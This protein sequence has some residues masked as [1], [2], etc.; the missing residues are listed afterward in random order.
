MAEFTTSG[1]IFH[2]VTHIAEKVVSAFNFFNCDIIIGTR[3]QNLFIHIETNLAY[4]TPCIFM[5]SIKPSA[6][7]PA[8]MAEELP[9]QFL[10]QVC[11]S[12]GVFFDAA[13]ENT[14]VLIFYANI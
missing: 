10:K 4:F 14:V 1:I 13:L 7:M 5:L 9:S 6:M 12:A 3:F 11:V 8:S 2:F